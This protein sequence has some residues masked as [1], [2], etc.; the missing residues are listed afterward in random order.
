MVKILLRKNNPSEDIQLDSLV[1]IFPQRIREA[2]FFN[3]V[4]KSKALK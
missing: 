3:L 2:E 1:V 4:P